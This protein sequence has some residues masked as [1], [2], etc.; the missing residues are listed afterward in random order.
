MWGGFGA[1]SCERF[2]F[3]INPLLKGGVVPTEDMECR[4]LRAARRYLAIEAAQGIIGK[5][6]HEA[7]TNQ[8]EN[9]HKPSKYSNAETP[10]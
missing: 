9:G 2:E 8:K 7:E 3:K 1:C 6:Q 5:R 4:H 10:Y